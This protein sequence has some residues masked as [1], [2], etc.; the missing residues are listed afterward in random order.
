MSAIA[1]CALEKVA[2]FEE[3]VGSWRLPCVGERLVVCKEGSRIYYRVEAVLW[4]IDHIPVADV[5]GG[6]RMI[7]R[8][9][10]DV[11]KLAEEGVT[12]DERAVPN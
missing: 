7:H 8:V 11:S 4:V 6:E 12:K 10:I 9:E 5:Y 3:G 2:V 1:W